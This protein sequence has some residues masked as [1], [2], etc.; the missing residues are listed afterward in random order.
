MIHP[1]TGH[2]KGIAEGDWV[3][4]ESKTGKVKQ[5]ARLSTAVARKVIVAE[6]G[7]W[8]PEQ[9]HETFYGFAESN[10][11]ALTNDG[12]PFNPEVGS[13]TVRGIACKVYRAECL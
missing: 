9:G 2:E 8:Y 13:F 3:F 5:K 10:Y 4:I 12:P 6:H 7:W 11:N 1:D